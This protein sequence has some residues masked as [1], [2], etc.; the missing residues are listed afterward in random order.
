M[1]TKN[2]FKRI[3][4]NDKYCRQLNKNQLITAVWQYGGRSASKTIWC[5]K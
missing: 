1:P 2:K 5:L 4:L 3:T